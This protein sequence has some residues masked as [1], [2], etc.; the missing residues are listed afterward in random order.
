MILR[1]FIILCFFWV[2]LTPEAM[3]AF[4]KITKSEII[5]GVMD[6][7]SGLS[8]VIYATGKKNGQTWEIKAYWKNGYPQQILFTN[9][10][11]GL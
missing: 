2:L 1:A 7:E 8:G 4:G 11:P 9:S 10:E 6:L 5:S 3:D